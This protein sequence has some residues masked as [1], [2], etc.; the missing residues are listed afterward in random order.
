ML[1]P[2]ERNQ[3]LLGAR[4]AIILLPGVLAGLG[5]GILTVLDRKSPVHGVL[6]DGAAFAAADPMQYFWEQF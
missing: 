1:N 6:A 4:A 5:A 3:P 2:L